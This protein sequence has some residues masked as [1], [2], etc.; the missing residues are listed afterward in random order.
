M[1]YQPPFSFASPLGGG[2]RGGTIDLLQYHFLDILWYD[3]L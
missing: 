1:G 3:Y 2:K